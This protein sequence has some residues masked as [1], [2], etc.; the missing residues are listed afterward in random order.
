[1][2]NIIRKFNQNR[3]MIIFDLIIIALVIIVIQV[4]NSII[5]NNNK[6]AQNEN[7]TQNNYS[8]YSKPK[9]VL[10]EE[11][12]VTEENEK[13][14]DVVDTF[15]KYCNEKNPT[16]AYKLLSDDCK[17]QLF[18]TE[19]EFINDYY[20]HFFNTSKKYEYELWISNYGRY[21]YK[22]KLY[23]DNL[24]STGG[25]DTTYIE[26]YYTIV[27]KDDKYFLNINGYVDNKKIDKSASN[28]NITITAKEKDIFM[29]Y[30]TYIIE[31]H[32]QT[33]KNILIDSKENTDTMYISDEN[34]NKYPSYIHEV[35]RERLRIGPNQKRTVKIKYTKQYTS[36]LSSKKIVFSDI[37]LDYDLYKQKANTKEYIGRSEISIDL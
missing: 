24:M 10:K 19:E 25:Q 26:E 8:S 31:I 33:N 29:E 6:E 2:N 11:T 3:K 4:V 30:E 27:N 34:E 32:N 15:I 14:V 36:S 5:K 1:M 37:I 18:S 35:S 13:S 7:I 23:E 12:V 9:T 17:E 21:T 22:I 20:A 16:E 28:N